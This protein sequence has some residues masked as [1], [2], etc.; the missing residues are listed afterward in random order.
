QKRGFT[1]IELLV[2][3]LIMGILA[4]V[5]LPQ[6]RVAVVKTRLGTMM[7]IVDGM[8]KSLDLYYLENGSW[9]S[10]ANT[11]IEWTIDFPAGCSLKGSAAGSCSNG[12]FID[13]VGSQPD[14]MICSAKYHIGY[15]KISNY[16]SSFASSSYCLAMAEDQTAEQ[17]CRSMGGRLSTDYTHTYFS[18]QCA[19]GKEMHIYAL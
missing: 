16:A 6:Y 10:S 15:A 19:E 2:V 17:V 14:V 1:L 11:D 5:A 3:V 4:A 9:P 7:P 12:L 18:S 8:L 13:I